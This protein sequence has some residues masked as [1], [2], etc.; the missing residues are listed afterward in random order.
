MTVLFE[1][2]DEDLGFA[3]VYRNMIEDPRLGDP[4]VR[5]LTWMTSHAKTFEIRISVLR[6]KLRF[7]KDKWRTARD[8]LTK[9]GYLHI[10]KWNGADGRVKYKYTVF[11]KPRPQW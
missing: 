8:Q 7:G 5:A 10:R 4:A 9:T 6:R 1:Q 11:R 2:G 3:I